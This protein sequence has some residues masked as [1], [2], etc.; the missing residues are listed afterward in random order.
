LLGS[1][2]LRKAAIEAG[3]GR[4]DAARGSL[5]AL[6]GNKF[7]PNRDKASA[8][9]R[10]GRWWRARDDERKATAYFERVYVA[11]GKFR[12]LVAEAYLERGRS[13]E[14]LGEREKAVE[15][16]RVLTGRDDLVE[17]GEVV[18]EARERLEALEG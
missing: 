13:L 7:V 4:S 12:D 15:T 1:V 18:G 3:L 11:Y 16:Y 5:D 10:Y 8:L 6:L 9:M 17:F 14:A 2:L